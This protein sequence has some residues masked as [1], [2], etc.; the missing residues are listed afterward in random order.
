[1]YQVSSRIWSYVLAFLKPT[2]LRS[3]KSMAGRLSPF[4][5]GARPYF[6]G[7]WLGGGNSNRFYCRPYLRKTSNLTDIFQLGARLMGRCGLATT[8]STQLEAHDEPA[9]GSSAVGY[10]DGIIQRVV[11]HDRSGSSS[12]H[13]APSLHGKTPAMER[14]TSAAAWTSRLEIRNEATRT[15]FPASS[16]QFMWGKVRNLQGF[17]GTYVQTASAACNG[18]AIHGGDSVSELLKRISLHAATSTASAVETRWVSTAFAGNFVAISLQRCAHQRGFANSSQGPRVSVGRSYASFQTNM[19]GG[20]TRQRISA[21]ARGHPRTTGTSSPTWRSTWG[22]YATYRWD[23]GGRTPGANGRSGTRRKGHMGASSGALVEH[24]AGLCYTQ[25]V[26]QNSARWSGP[27]SWFHVVLWHLTVGRNYPCGALQ[28][29]EETHGSSRTGSR[30][31]CPRSDKALNWRAEGI[32]QLHAR[33]ESSARHCSHPL[34]PLCICRSQ[35]WGRHGGVGR[36]VQC[37]DRLANCGGDV[38]HCLSQSALQSSRS[39]RPSQ[40]VQTHGGKALHR[41]HR[42]TT[43]RDL[44]GG[45]NEGVDF[46]GWRTTS[47]TDPSGAVGI[48]GTV[49]KAAGTGGLRQRLDAYLAAFSGASSEDPHPMPHG[50]PS[51]LMALWRCSIYLEDTRDAVDQDDPHGRRGAGGAGN[52]WGG[53]RQAHIHDGFWSSSL[54]SLLGEVERQLHRCEE[55]DCT[56]GERSRWPLPHCTGE[57]ISSTS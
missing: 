21:Y 40:V 29:S 20:Q 42:C 46:A 35:T 54:Q 16:M 53:L 22:A 17:V 15:W 51:T 43:V 30:S 39:S 47:I 10:Q 25:G 28:H 31:T 36:E 4:L 14:A 50:T 55:M 27:S 2:V 33:W 23:R 7:L 19:D 6:Q 18:K 38:R 48:G 57:G 49:S 34:Y 45:K 1:M 41:C 37:S 5:F 24:S 9:R 11:F 26:R 52:V 32:L 8:E 56:P 13:A 3:W 44:V 12:R